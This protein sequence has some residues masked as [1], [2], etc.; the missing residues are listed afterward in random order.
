MIGVDEEEVERTR[1]VARKKT[2]HLFILFWFSS[3]VMASTTRALQQ[4]REPNRQLMV[5]SV[6]GLPIV[7]ESYDVAQL[8]S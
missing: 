5:L 7:G 4:K 8:C 1:I 3:T 2:Q 6:T